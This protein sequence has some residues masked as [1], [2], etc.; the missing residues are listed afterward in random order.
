LSGYPGG[1][2]KPS[3]NIPRAQALIAL[4]SGLN[5]APSQPVSNTLSANFT[6]ANTIPSYAYNGIAAATERHLVVDYPDVRYLQPNQLATRAD[7]SA[8]L[9]QAFAGSGQVSSIP[10]QYIAGGS[11][12]VAALLSSGITIPVRYPAAKKLAISPKETVPLT[13]TVAADVS[14]SQGTVVIPAG[15]Q[16]AGQLQPVNGGSQ[17]VASQVTINGSQY[18]INASSNPIKTTQNLRSANIGSILQDALLGSGAAAGISAI[19]GDRTI[20]AGKVLTGTLVGSA[21]GANTNRNLGS[22]ALDTGLGAAAGAGVAGLTGDRGITGGKVLAGA[23]AGATLGGI[24]DHSPTSK[25]VV[26]NPNS[27][28]NL[29]LN[30][31]FN[32]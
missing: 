26:I 19:T 8:F 6:D 11:N 18:P 4:A 1:I 15:S 28:L 13:L 12:Q 7:I 17:F 2:F 14:N 30:S 23:A 5:Y 27:D 25:V 9:C 29:T 24:L 31:D 32:K 16:I 3:Q 21:V 22:T 20:T 10:A